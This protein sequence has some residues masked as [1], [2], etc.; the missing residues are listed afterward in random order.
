MRIHVLTYTFVTDVI[1]KDSVW[2][3]GHWGDMK[4]GSWEGQDGGE[5]M[6]NDAIAFQ[7]KRFT[8]KKV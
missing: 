1:L 7:L 4:E 3:S 8:N 6:E 5:G 2:Q